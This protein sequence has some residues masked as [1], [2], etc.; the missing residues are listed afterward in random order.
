MDT[1]T[2][3]ISIPN[4]T[5]IDSMSDREALMAVQA[6]YDSNRRQDRYE[7]QWIAMWWADA[8]RVDEL[9]AVPE[10]LPNRQRETRSEAVNELVGQY[11]SYLKAVARGPHLVTRMLGGVH[12]QDDGFLIGTTSWIFAGRAKATPFEHQGW[13]IISREL[14]DVVKALERANGLGRGQPT[15][16]FMAYNARDAVGLSAMTGGEIGPCLSLDEVKAHI[17]EEVDSSAS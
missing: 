16:F 4:I 6:I 8:F 2:P 15:R 11:K 12:V 9:L 17:D 1:S 13:T 14:S 3:N 10:S 7:P 5:N